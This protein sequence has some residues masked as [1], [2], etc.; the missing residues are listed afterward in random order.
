[1]RFKNLQLYAYHKMVL[2]KSPAATRFSI[3]SFCRRNPSVTGRENKKGCDDRKKEFSFH[4]RPFIGAKKL[5]TS[6]WLLVVPHDKKKSAYRYKQIRSLW[7][8][9]R[10]KK[11]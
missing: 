3:G 11:I 4:N 1:M 9:N 6:K 7:S 8:N 2:A 10:P 5:K